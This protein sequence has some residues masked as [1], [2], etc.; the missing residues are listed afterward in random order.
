MSDLRVWHGVGNLSTRATTLL[1]TVL[2]LDSTVGRYR[3][4]KFRDSSPGQFRDSNSG[5]PGKITIWMPP[6]PRAAEYT[7]RGK[8]VAS[9]QV[10]VV[11]SLVCPCCPWLVL[12]PKVLQLCTL[13][14]LCAGPC[15]WISLSI[16]PSPIPELQHAP[17]PLQVLWAKERLQVPTPSALPHTWTLKWV[18]KELGS[19]SQE[20]KH[21]LKWMQNAFFVGGFFLNISNI[22][23]F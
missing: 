11:V 1:Q 12:A 18:Y 19:A 2:R 5:V 3:R 9:P 15:E 14:G 16:L 17:L 10:R 20:Q 21:L 4:S 7:I 8:V 23:K 6:P 22:V 13:C